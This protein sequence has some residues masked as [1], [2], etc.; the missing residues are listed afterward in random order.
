MGWI[1]KKLVDH[2]KITNLRIKADSTMLID[3]ED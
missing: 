1:K 2:S 3:M